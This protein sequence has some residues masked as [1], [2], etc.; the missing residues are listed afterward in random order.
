MPYDEQKQGNLD[1][2]EFLCYIRIE[3]IARSAVVAINIH[4]TYVISYQD[5][6]E[7]QNIFLSFN[8]GVS[9]KPFQYQAK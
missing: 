6:V 7:L 9:D 4:I 8:I 2:G 1:E 5:R 3:R